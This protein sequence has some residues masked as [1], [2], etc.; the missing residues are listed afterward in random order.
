MN[1]H[2]LEEGWKMPTTYC[3]CTNNTVVAWELLHNKFSSV[4]K[5]EQRE[6][7][8]TIITQ[9]SW[10]AGNEM[11]PWFIREN[12]NFE[13]YIATSSDDDP[14]SIA[15]CYQ[16]TTTT[17]LPYNINSGGWRNKKYLIGKNWPLRD[18]NYLK[19]NCYGLG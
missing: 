2:I 10:R 5:F 17:Q 12:N 13:G 3:L 6:I 4:P 16:P 11:K 9:V 15:E 14:T 7:S 8:Q 1:E 19:S 18:M